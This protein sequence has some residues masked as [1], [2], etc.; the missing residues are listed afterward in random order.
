MQ[1][2]DHVSNAEVRSIEADIATLLAEIASI[3]EGDPDGLFAPSHELP[4]RIASYWA[5]RRQLVRHEIARIAADLLDATRT[6]LACDE[7]ELSAEGKRADKPRSLARV[8]FR[9]IK[10]PTSVLGRDAV[11]CRVRQLDQEFRRALR[12][13]TTDQL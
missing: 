11:R 6:L 1:I 8:E 7:L 12:A 13:A 3:P 5:N 9:G 4:R 10:V 2:D